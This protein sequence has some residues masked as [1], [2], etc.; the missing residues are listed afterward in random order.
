MKRWGLCLGPSWQSSVQELVEPAQAAEASGFN[1]IT[2]GEYRSD[3]ITW[4]AILAAATSSVRLATT[5]SSI[6]LRHPTVTAEAIAALRDVYGDRIELGLGVSHP[7][8]VQDDLGLGQPSLGALEDYVT[9]VRSILSGTSVATASYRAPEHQRTRR[10]TSKVPILV[11]A[12]GEVAAARAAQYADGIILTWS[13]VNY[14]RGIVDSVRTQDDTSGRR[15]KIW[16][17]LPVFRVDDTSMARV[18]CARHLRPYLNLPSYRRMLS[19]AT[20]EPDRIERAARDGVSDRAAADILGSDLLDGI[21]ALGGRHGVTA[22]IR[23]MY[24]AGVDDVILYPLD[25]GLGW[26]EAVEST[27]KTCSPL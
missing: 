8:T 17:V 25:T 23:A 2:T 26:R 12:L 10:I 27:I 20:A 21:A 3:A 16:V 14:T 24:D 1:R 6:A 7:S 18:A 19:A 13:H 22:A 5:I 4:L 11:S 15:T 9:T